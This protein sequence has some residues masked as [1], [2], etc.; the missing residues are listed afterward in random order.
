MFF[1]EPFCKFSVILVEHFKAKPLLFVTVLSVFILVAD[2]THIKHILRRGGHHYL[3]VFL[4][5]LFNKW[6]LDKQLLNLSVW[7]NIYW[8][9]SVVKVEWN[10]N[11]KN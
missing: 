10:N 8:S 6:A 11:I 9:S 3:A 2:I 4:L 5:G 1:T 7:I